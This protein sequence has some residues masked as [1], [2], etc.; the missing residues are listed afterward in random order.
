MMAPLI[1]GSLALPA[2]ENAEVRIALEDITE[3]DS[4]SKVLAQTRIRAAGRSAAFELDVPDSK[5]GPGRDYAL[6]AR[7]WRDGRVRAATVSLHSWAPGDSGPHHLQL[8]AFD[9]GGGEQQ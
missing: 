2:V 7:A 4:P 3:Q 1:R 5:L 8:I 9:Q 6:T